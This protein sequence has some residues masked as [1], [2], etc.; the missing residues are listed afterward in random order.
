[1]SSTP[2]PLP[3]DVRA[4]LA[5]LLDAAEGAVHAARYASVRNLLESVESVIQNKVPDP[6]ERQRLLWGCGVVRDALVKDDATA[7][8]YLWSMHRRVRAA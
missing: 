3:A 7:S 8:A 6:E 5:Q 2:P 1:M 4:V